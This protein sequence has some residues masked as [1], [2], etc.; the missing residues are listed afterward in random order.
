LSRRQTLR[1]TLRFDG[2]GDE[3]DAGLGVDEVGP[4][5]EGVAL[6]LR[7]PLFDGELGGRTEADDG[8]GRGGDH[9]GDFLCKPLEVDFETNACSV[10]C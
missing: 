1:D 9:D 7:P 2:L 5:A 10:H 6:C 4:C 3:E 8:G